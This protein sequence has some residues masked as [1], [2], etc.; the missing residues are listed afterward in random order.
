MP[1][2]AKNVAARLGA[3]ERR[4]GATW[5]TLD[6]AFSCS[7]GFIHEIASLGGAGRRC[8]VALPNHD[9]DWRGGVA[10]NFLDVVAAELVAFDPALHVAS[11]ARNRGATE[12][13][14]SVAGQCPTR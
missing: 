10:P 6:L 1:T 12:G 3:L 7:E 2:K 4:D 5:P 8:I 14:Q 11:W 13:A 9:C